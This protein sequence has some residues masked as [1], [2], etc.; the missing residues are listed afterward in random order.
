MTIDGNNNN[1]T[2]NICIHGQGTPEDYTENIF[3]LRVKGNN[4]IV[5]NNHCGGKAPTDSG[6]NNTLV[7]NKY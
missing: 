5:S 2:G 3:S 7:N 1:I 4:C 6:T